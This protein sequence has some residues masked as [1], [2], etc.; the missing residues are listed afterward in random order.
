M[1]IARHK[2]LVLVAGLAVGMAPLAAADFGGKIRPLMETYCF[3]C[4]DGETQEGGVRLDDLTSFEEGSQHL[5]TSI[6]EQL[7]SG[8]MPPAK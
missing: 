8:Q 7:S 1:R 5:W 2:F 4:H 6:F 3:D